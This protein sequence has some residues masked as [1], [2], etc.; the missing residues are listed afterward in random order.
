MSART[1]SGGFELKGAHVAWMMALF[2]GGVIAINV[3]FA[4][5]AV[6]TF[7]GEEGKSYELGLHYNQALAERREEAALGWSARLEHAVD[8]DGAPLLRV[9]VTGADGAPIQGLQIAAQLRRPVDSRLDR[10][11][12]FVAAGEGV[13][14]AA[15]PGDLP[16][17]L[18][19]LRAVAQREQQRFSFE[20]EIT[21]RPQP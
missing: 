20:R 14:A 13:Y 19:E 12:S 9:Q 2:F 5:L 6:R 1:A 8:A 18:W 11:L 17:G 15:V 7:P 10:A 4:V 21:W 3:I 16:A